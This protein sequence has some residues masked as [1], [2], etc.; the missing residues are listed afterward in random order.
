MEARE[1]DSEFVARPHETLKE[2]GNEY[3]PIPQKEIGFNHDRKQNPG[4]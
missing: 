1:P 2:N 4:Y 3:F